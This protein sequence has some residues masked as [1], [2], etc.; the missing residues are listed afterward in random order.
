MRWLSSQKGGLERR[1][2]GSLCEGTQG[3][4]RWD[5]GRDWSYAATEEEWPGPRSWKRQ[6]RILQVS[7]EPWPSGHLDFGLFAC[8]PVRENISVVVSHPVS[9]YG[10]PRK[11]ASGEK[12]ITLA[13]TSSVPVMGWGAVVRASF[14]PREVGEVGIVMI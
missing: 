9:L 1:T 11:P 4:A 6:R 8:R 13:K 14:C 2:E 12:V 5:G 7:E 10:G 3:D